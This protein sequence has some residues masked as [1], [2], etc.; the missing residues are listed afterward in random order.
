MKNNKPT[1]RIRK[2]LQNLQVKYSRIPR[3]TVRHMDRYHP[4]NVKQTKEAI[5]RFWQYK[6]WAA[7]QKAKLPVSVLDDHGRFSLVTHGDRLA[8]T[9]ALEGIT[10]YVIRSGQ[11][12]KF[13]YLEQMPLYAIPLT[14]PKDQ[15]R[16]KE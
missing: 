1:R 6:R 5:K 11:A 2:L 15:S 3:A 13:W 7:R 16:Y 14:K 10:P 8:A 9:P 12:A 4:L